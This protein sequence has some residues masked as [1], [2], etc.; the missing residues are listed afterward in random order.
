MIKYK[1]KKSKFRNI[2]L[3]ICVIILVYTVLN[4]KSTP[5]HIGILGITIVFMYI[6]R[7]DIIPYLG[8]QRPR[9]SSKDNTIIPKDEIWFDDYYTLKYI[10]EKTIAIGEPRYW[11]NNYNY[12][13]IG[14]EKAILFDSGPGVRDIKPVIKSLTNLPVISM[15]S[16]YHF[17]HIGSINGFEEVYLGENQL[18]R[19][20]ITKNNTIK[21]NK[22]SFIGSIEGV[23]AKEFKLDKVIRNKEVIDLG[24][25]KI[26]ILDAPGHDCESIVLYDEASNQLFAGDYLMKG[27]ILAHKL[28][29]PTCSLEDY[30]YTIKNILDNINPGTLIYVAHPLDFSNQTM[31]Y[32]DIKQLNDFFSSVEKNN[33]IPKKKK[34]NDYIDVI[35]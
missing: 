26:K 29:M 35:Y 22:K 13:I 14:D 28:S 19:Q 15:I 32:D 23:K 30:K 2:I 1:N 27:P 10:D 24:N 7:Y 12:L 5:L 11:Q 18:K 20:T 17:D 6:K 9:V 31:E 21:P 33:I 8:V 25:R 4:F 34:I 16:H 3:L